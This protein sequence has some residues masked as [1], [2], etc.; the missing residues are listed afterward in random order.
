MGQQKQPP[1]SLGKKV[2]Y[3]PFKGSK[4]LADFV[5]NASVLA[6]YSPFDRA[7]SDRT[8]FVHHG[9]YHG[10]LQLRIHNRQAIQA[11]FVE[12]SASGAEQLIVTGHS[13]GGQYALAFLLDAF[14]ELQ[15]NAPVAAP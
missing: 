11:L 13:L 5:V 7:F 9:A 10:I 15:A 3:L 1:M 14:L 2:L 12:A 8:T 4:F 6:D